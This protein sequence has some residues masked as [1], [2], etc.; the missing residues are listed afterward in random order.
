MQDTGYPKLSGT[1]PSH[2][3]PTPGDGGTPPTHRGRAGRRGERTRREGAKFATPQAPS[4]SETQRAPRTLQ[5]SPHQ[6]QRASCLEPPQRGPA[7]PTP[8]ARTPLC[9]PT[10]PAAPEPGSRPRTRSSTNPAHGPARPSTAPCRSRPG[11][12]A[13]AGAHTHE[14]TRRSSGA[15]PSCQPRAAPRGGPSGRRAAA[16]A[17]EQRPAPASAR[18]EGPV[19]LA[20]CAARGLLSEGRPETPRAARRAAAGRKLGARPARS[21]PR[22]SRA[23]PPRPAPKMDARPRLP[24]PRRPRGPAA[25]PGS[26]T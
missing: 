4:R 22:R 14:G 3:A 12:A 16:W 23:P 17:G 11:A 1:N 15:R 18:E 24:G 6:T 2:T 7:F 9:R 5:R 19:Q 10:A 8:S 20:G 21:S 26:V 25:P 13:P